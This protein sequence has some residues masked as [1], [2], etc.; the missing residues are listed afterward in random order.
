VNNNNNKS[1]IS[2]QA[3]QLSTKNPCTIYKIKLDFLNQSNLKTSDKFIFN[4]LCENSTRTIQRDTS[5]FSSQF[6]F[7][8]DEMPKQYSVYQR[9]I[10][11]SNVNILL[12]SSLIIFF[13]N[14][15]EKNLEL[16]LIFF[17]NRISFNL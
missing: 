4:Q 9:I 3:Q 7:N 13:V 14:F 1:V 11:A 16:N 17:S 8:D 5:N 6:I 12:L 10:N 15:L 2:Q